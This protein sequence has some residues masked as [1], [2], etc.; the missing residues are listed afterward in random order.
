MAPFSTS[1]FLP[2]MVSLM[3][4]AIGIKKATLDKTEDSY[5]LVLALMIA[6]TGIV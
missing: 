1:T 6:L 4:S 2:S 3:F 5:L